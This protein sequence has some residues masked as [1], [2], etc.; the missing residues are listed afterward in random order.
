MR[1]GKRFV[2]VDEFA[3]QRDKILNSNATDAAKL[4]A[5]NSLDENYYSIGYDDIRTALI[6][7]HS[8]R[9]Q[10]KI[11]SFG[12]IKMPE[13]TPEPAKAGTATPPPAAAETK[14]AKKAPSVSSASDN[15]DTTKKGAHQTGKTGDDVVKA[16]WG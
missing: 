11:N 12:G 7:L 10:N 4:R 15:T 9:A 14:G 3:G 5:I 13:G 8:T 6:A 1:G 16:M 2:T